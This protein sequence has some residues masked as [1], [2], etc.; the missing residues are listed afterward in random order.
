M[1]ELGAF[2]NNEHLRRVAA[3]EPH[4]ENLLCSPWDGVEP[5]SRDLLRFF[6]RR[7]CV[8]SCRSVRDGFGSRRAAGIEVVL[9]RNL[10][11]GSARG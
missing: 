4:W 7:A 6:E 1:S 10:T 11:G 9:L 3:E 8:A 5:S 2:P